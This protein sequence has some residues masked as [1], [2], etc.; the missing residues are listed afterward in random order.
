MHK[1]LSKQYNIGTHALSS[2][3]RQLNFVVQRPWVMIERNVTGTFTRD[4]ILVE[5]TTLKECVKVS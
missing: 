3:K 2:H 4:V 5:Q 1:S